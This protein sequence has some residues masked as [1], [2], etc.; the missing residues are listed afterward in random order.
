MNFDKT[1]VTRKTKSLRDRLSEKDK[2]SIYN[3]RGYDEMRA[4]K[5]AVDELIVTGKLS[6]EE[7]VEQIRYLNLC[8]K[9]HTNTKLEENLI[10]NYEINKKLDLIMEHN[11][12]NSSINSEGEQQHFASFRALTEKGNK[13]RSIKELTKSD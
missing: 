6:H 2:R 9:L 13:I 3:T 10:V 12:N 4:S 7:G 8:F 1:K 5:N 11:E